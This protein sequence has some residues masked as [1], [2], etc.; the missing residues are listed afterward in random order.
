MNLERSLA[1]TLVPL[2][3]NADV[4]L[5]RVKCIGNR[6]GWVFIDIRRNARAPLTLVVLTPM[7]L[8]LNQFCGFTGADIIGQ[9]AEAERRYG[10]RATRWRRRRSLRL[11]DVSD[12]E[13]I[14]TSL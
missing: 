11:G 5:A 10:G 3:G 1:H 2:L 8:Y 13:D 14:E 6:D 9:V 12:P 4:D 7:K